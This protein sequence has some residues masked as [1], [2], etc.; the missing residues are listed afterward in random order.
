MNEYD[1]SEH[2]A[3]KVVVENLWWKYPETDWI[4]KDIRFKI[5][6]GEFVVV[7]GPNDSGK[8][9]LA[10]SLNGLIPH[11]IRGDMKGRVTVSGMDTLKYGIEDVSTKVGMVFDDPEAQ[12]ILTKVEDEIAFGP[13]NLGLSPEETEKRIIWALEV[14]RLKDQIFK[15]PAD[16]SGG[17]K[18]RA[19]IAATLAMKPEILVLD[20]PTSMLDPIGKAEVMSVL[21]ELKETQDI[22]IVVFEHHIEDLV[23]IADRFMLLYKGEIIREGKTQDF[24]SDP[25]FLDERGVRVPEVC[26]LSEKLMAEKVVGTVD[27]TLNQARDSLSRSLKERAPITLPKRELEEPANLGSE[28]AIVTEGLRYKYPDGTVALRGVDLT[29]RRGEFIAL[30]GQNG[31]G[32]TTLSKTFNGLLRPTEGKV[33]VFGMDTA[34]VSTVDLALKVGYTFQNPDHQ[35]FKGSVK[36]ELEF[37]LDNLIRIR[38][39]DPREKDDRVRGAMKT[40]GIPERLLGEH[41]FM[42]SKGLRQRVAI[43]SILAMEPEVLIIDEPTTGQDMR[44]SIEVMSFLNDLNRLGHTIIVVT[45]EMWVVAKWA[46]RTV[47][48]LN[49]KILLDGPTREVFSQSKVLAETFVQPPQITRLAQELGNYGYP[50]DIMTVNE[51]YEATKQVI[52]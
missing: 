47:A 30:I 44:Q 6:E 34:K 8:T 27:L 41:P 43:G 16:L 25:S 38:R 39:L 20:E 35:L 48:M 40:A 37:G 1:R 29:I 19:A 21:R 33:S 49:G 23:E 2:M 28:I 36:G 10:R 18:Q 11:S 3:N 52:K 42:L 5:E 45:H 22:T 51:F 50:R 13:M 9:T 4:L 17:Q 26:L 12:F 46:R 32:K 15:D 7:V 14:T 24:F 31:S